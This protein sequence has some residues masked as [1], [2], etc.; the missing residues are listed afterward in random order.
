MKKTCVFTLL[1]I[2]LAGL[3]CFSAP[4]EMTWEQVSDRLLSDADQPVPEEMRVTV[5]KNGL[6]PAGGL[7][8]RKENLL[9][10]FT[11]AQNPEND[12]GRAQALLICSVDQKTGHIRIFRVPEDEKA[13]I[14]ELPES[15]PWKY[16]SCFGGGLL[17]CRTVN[18]AFSL[19]VVKY[20]AV[21]ADALIQLID[22][23]GGVTL[24]LTEAEAEALE[25]ETGERLL[26]G[27][28]ALR[29]LRLR[30]NP[31]EESRTGKM[32]KA[33][34]DKVFETEGCEGI[35]EIGEEMLSLLDSNLSTND[36]IDLILAVCEQDIPSLMFTSLPPEEALT[37]EAVHSRLF[38]EDEK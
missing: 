23:I 34:F 18:E 2:L 22:R 38:S 35:L 7:D 33:V 32:M 25:E 11:D 21:N 9:L 8:K 31:Q 1:L 24:P 12:F 16:V 5:K 37:P 28:K 30:Q 3:L 20:C 17:L 10:Y 27:E 14:P 26:G 6:K 29:Y 36:L 13:A 15:I 19:N 4:A